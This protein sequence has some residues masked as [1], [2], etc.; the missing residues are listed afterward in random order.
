MTANLLALSST[1]HDSVAVRRRRQAEAIKR[2]WKDGAPA[3]TLAALCQVPELA[4]DPVLCLDL[5]YEEYCI[6]TDAGEE[7]DVDAFCGRFPSCRS[8]LKRLIKLHHAFAAVPELIHKLQPVPD[9]PAPDRTAT[10]W[11]KPGDHIGDFTVLRELGRGKFARAFLATEASTGDRPVVLKLS[12][13]E[14]KEARTLGRLQHPYIVPVLSAQARPDGMTVLCMPYQGTVTIENVLDGLFSPAG[15]PAPRLASALL[16]LLARGRHPDDPEL[17]LPAPPD[18]LRKGSYDEAVLRLGEQLADA[19]DFL[20]RHRVCHRDLKPSNLLLRPDGRLLLLD[21]NLSVDVRL[22]PLHVGGTVP[23]MAPEQIQALLD[24]DHGPPL[25]ERVDLFSFGVILYELLTGKYPFGPVPARLSPRETGL[26]L[27]ER[28]REGCPP[29]GRLCPQL[30]RRVADLLERCLAFDRRRRP[31]SAAV[32]AEL[33]RHFLR[34]Q[35]QRTR[36]LLAVGCLAL[37]STTLL[38]TTL[39]PRG[40]FRA[41]APAQVRPAPAAYFAAGLDAFQARRYV[42]AADAFTRVLDAEP[43]HADAHFLAGRTQLG[44]V[45]YRRARD[46]FEQALNVE[47]TRAWPGVIGM[48]APGG[49]AD[50][51]L[52]VNTLLEKEQSCGPTLAYLAYCDSH[53]RQPQG[54]DKRGREAL[55]CGFAT[56]A[57]YNNL[58]YS[59]LQRHRYDDAQRNL[60]EALR[61]DPNLQA[62]HLNCAHRAVRLRISDPSKSIPQDALDHL[63]QALC[64]NNQDPEMYLFGARLYALAARDDPSQEAAHKG[65]AIA[66]LQEAIR[67]G[68][69]ASAVTEITFEG[70]VGHPQFPALVSTPQGT[71]A[72]VR[73]SPFLVDPLALQE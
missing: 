38:V 19:L 41:E 68:V 52:A 7:P 61:L 36:S 53:L 1:P 72:A 55:A 4:A 17:E 6:R 37:V 58:A 15:G 34:R 3:D 65:K 10:A 31:A 71:I 24:L 39:G 14:N 33:R 66:L 46:H 27:L 69:P 23:Y 45:N 32:L 73:P 5:A 67:R 35:K 40:A 57:V 13:R 2:A 22:A 11:P 9:E 54:A 63:E 60:D 47:R 44:L 12:D 26:L 25:D 49:G 64:G 59:L 42:E 21:F 56:P 20:H 51:L 70:L 48:A 43:L 30:P 28:Q 29:L 62:A 18:W 8:S 50:R 16:D